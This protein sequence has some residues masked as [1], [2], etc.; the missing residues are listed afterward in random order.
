MGQSLV[1]QSL[2][3][4]YLMGQS[5]LGYFA[6]NSHLGGY[7]RR[8]DSRWT[9]QASLLALAKTRRDHL[10]TYLRTPIMTATKREHDD[11]E[12][13]S[14]EAVKKLKMGDDDPHSLTLQSNVGVIQGPD[15][16]S[17]VDLFSALFYAINTF[18]QDYFKGAPYSIARR[19][20][21][22]AFFESLT[23][24]DCKG[25]LKSKHPGAKEAIMLAA[26]WNKLI[27]YLLSAPTR[28]FINSIPEITIRD[29]ASGNI[30][31]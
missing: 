15:D 1:G 22:K 28:A 14:S 6:L 21:E 16:A 13:D 24:S 10:D 3:G 27:N 31:P 4:Q 2:V 7:I 25:Y 9:N 30:L 26:I 19:N 23:G 18:V 20:D 5:L 11:G 12:P 8:A 17:I 29:G